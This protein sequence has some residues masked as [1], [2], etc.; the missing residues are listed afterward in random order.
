MELLLPGALFFLIWWLLPDAPFGRLLVWAFGSIVFAAIAIRNRPSFS[1]MDFDPRL[2][3]VF[4]AVMGVALAASV[5][6]FIL[7]PG[8]R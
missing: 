3:Y 4:L 2:W 7:L 5:A 6:G 1:R 8:I